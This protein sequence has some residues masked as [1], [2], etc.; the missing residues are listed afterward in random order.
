[1][2]ENPY[3]GP[4]VTTRSPSFPD[5]NVGLVMSSEWILGTPERQ[6][7]AADAVVESWRSRG[8]PAGLHSYTILIGTDGSTLRHYSRWDSESAFADFQAQQ[9]D[10]R[11]TPVDEKVPGI[12]RQG[13]QRY[14]L[15]RAHQTPEPAVS[16]ETV[17][18][19]TGTFTNRAEIEAFV[20]GML[21][22]QT[23][24]EEPTGT[25][26]LVSAHFHVSL[27]GTELL[28][29]ARWTDDAAYEKSMGINSADPLPPG[30]GRFRV[31]ST[32]RPQAR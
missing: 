15:Y 2:N 31:H 11:V 10:E 29:Y 25:D 16:P 1:M 3:A 27:D 24:E 32:L 6:R 20:D 18:I 30:V 5:P 26:D 19:A 7:A 12:V 8:W 21:D 23:P 14:R 28:N 13:L 17:V 9:R 22:S 4:R